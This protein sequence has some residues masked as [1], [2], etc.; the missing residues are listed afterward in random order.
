MFAW[1]W[2]LFYL[3]NRPIFRWKTGKQAQVGLRRTCTSQKTFHENDLETAREQKPSKVEL[4]RPAP[5]R[6]DRP[7]ALPAAGAAS[8]ARSE[9]GAAPAAAG[10]SKRRSPQPLLGFFPAQ[11]E[12]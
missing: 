1:K 12:K 9:P 7:V 3:K 5:C 11:Y 6:R 8:P 10:V 4:H 2:A